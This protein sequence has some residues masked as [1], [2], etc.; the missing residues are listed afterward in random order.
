MKV[1]LNDQNRLFSGARL[2]CC[3]ESFIVPRE[4]LDECDE[5]ACPWCKEP[6]IMKSV[7]GGWYS[8]WDKLRI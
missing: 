1:L 7:H 8:V 3:N 2:I 6:V 5:V 4:A